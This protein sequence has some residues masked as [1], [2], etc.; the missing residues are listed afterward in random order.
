MT[1][2]ITP[3]GLCSVPDCDRKHRAR[4]YCDAHLKRVKKYGDPGGPIGKTG[5]RGTVPI[6]VVV[7]EVEFLLGSETPKRI[8]QRIGYR[9]LDALTCHPRPPRRPPRPRRQTPEGRL[10]PAAIRP[11]SYPGCPKNVHSHNLCSGHNHQRRTGLPLAPLG[12]YRQGPKRPA[13]RP[14][15]I[16]QTVWLV[17][18]GVRHLREVVGYRG[19]VVLLDEVA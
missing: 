19:A 15:A 8:A 18:D 9:T 13:P 3:D 1:A 2:R 10:M 5:A 6:D 17:R 16:G 4:G 7:E 11:C 12:T 14:L